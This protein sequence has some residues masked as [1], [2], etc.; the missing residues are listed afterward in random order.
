MKNPLLYVFWAYRILFSPV[1]FF[2]AGTPNI[3]R[4]HPTCSRY[5][6][7]AIVRHGLLKGMLLTVRRVI[8]CHRGNR[9]GYDP[10]PIDGG[11]SSFI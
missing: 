7:G 10:V 11:N 9:G 3:C 8:L 1:W 6:E 2:V 4:F 5:A